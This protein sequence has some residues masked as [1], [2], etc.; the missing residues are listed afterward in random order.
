MKYGLLIESLIYGVQFDTV[1][2]SYTGVVKIPAALLNLME[3]SDLLKHLPSSD[4][5]D[6]FQ[7]LRENLK[8]SV[9]RNASQSTSP[10]IY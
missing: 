5:K 7:I 9:I 4:R 1:T 6:M 8:V 3:N 10:N 2:Y